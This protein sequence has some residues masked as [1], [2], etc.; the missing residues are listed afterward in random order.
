MRM[1]RKKSQKRLRKEQRK[2][3]RRQLPREPTEIRNPAFS[4]IAHM[5]LRPFVT[6]E[7]VDQVLDRE[8]ARLGERRTQ[9]AYARKNLPLFLVEKTQKMVDETAQML[10]ELG[11]AK[12]IIARH[13]LKV[14]LQKALPQ[15]VTEKQRR[16]R[17]LEEAFDS[18]WTDVKFRLG[19]VLSEDKD[20][21]REECRNQVKNSLQEAKE[22][23][24][25]LELVEKTGIQLSD[26]QKVFLAQQ[27]EA[28][29]NLAKGFASIPSLSREQKSA[30]I[31]YARAKKKKR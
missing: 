5:F 18:P 22:L 3:V 14:F 1:P 10:I 19:L 8:Y 12:K 7:S 24:L 17:N 16:I 11:R 21:S 27:A 20:I 2:M 9:L 28:E 23:R 30:L 13:G 29:V 26:K 31:K 25:I 6:G 15:L 4:S